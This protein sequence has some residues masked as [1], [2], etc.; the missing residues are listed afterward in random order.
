MIPNINKP[1]RVTANTATAMDHII[2]NVIIDTDFKTGIL[3][4][5]TSDHFAVMLAF[6]TGEKKMCNKSEQH[7][8]E[9]IF[10]ETLTESFRLRLWEIKWDNLKTSNDSNLAYNKFLD[11]FTSLY[12]NCFPRV[13]MK[14]K[15]RTSF[16][17]WITKGIAK[18]SKKK[19]KLYK[20]YLKNRKPQNLATYKTYKNVF[21]TIRKK[22][23]KS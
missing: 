10:N 20:R 21:E 15:A 18:P 4:S 6:R 7:I 5:C 11:T 12:P 16:K 3:K 8:H 1:T 14:V 19:Q 2:T 22:S 13:K 17:P 23:N 9:R